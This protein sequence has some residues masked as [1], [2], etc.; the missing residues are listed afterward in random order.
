[1]M[2]R[3]DFMM[4]LGGAAAWPFAARAQHP[5]MPV[6]GFLAGASPD[7]YSPLMAPFLQGLW[8]PI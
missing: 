5:T 2:K 4:L 1:M 6:I 8:R 7:A 3:R